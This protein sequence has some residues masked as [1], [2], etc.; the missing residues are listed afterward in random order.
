MPDGVSPGKEIRSLTGLRGIA[1]V[2][3]LLYHFFEND[4]YYA[5][6]VPTLVRRGYIGVDM[7]FVLSGFVMALSY[8]WVFRHS[9]TIAGYRDFMARRFA[10]I[11]PLYIL[12]TL[13]FVAKAFVNMS[14]TGPGRVYAGDVIASV[15]M[16]QSWGFGFVG[17]DIATWSLSTEFFAYLVFPALVF[18]AVF[19]RAWHAAAV[20]VLSGFAIYAVAASHLGIAGQLDVVAPDSFLPVLRCL[21][22]FCLGLV[23]YR[24][25]GTDLGSRLFSPSAFLL[26]MLVLLGVAAHFRLQDVVLFACFPFIVLALALNSAAARA[27]FANRVAHHLGVVSYSLYMVHPLLVPMKFR[28]QPVAERFIGDAAHPLVLAASLSLTWAA[29]CLLYRFVEKPGRLY[30]QR[31]LH[32]R[33]VVQKAA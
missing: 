32:S 19:G 21:A 11:Y 13:A 10:R 12:I 16:I 28:L 31:L 7:F 30:A 1:A 5:P 2:I 8:G 15:F 27:L 17:I 6:Y 25:A 4:A 33:T 20:C 9:L 18:F 3:V 14:G 29:A 23:C 24:V 26:G 22:G